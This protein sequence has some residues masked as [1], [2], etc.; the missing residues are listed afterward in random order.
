M[1]TILF[2]VGLAIAL[3]ME[4][5]GQGQLNIAFRPSSDF[6]VKDLGSTELKKGNGFDVKI[7]YRFFPRLAAY[8][9][10]GLNIFKPMESA[11]NTEQ[12]VETGYRFG[13]QFI[14][15]LSSQSKLNILLNAGGIANHI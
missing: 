11:N 1:K 14:R 5:Q 4:V 7:S 6:P 2:S 3:M 9:G 12:F 10:W 8:A 15:P 13:V